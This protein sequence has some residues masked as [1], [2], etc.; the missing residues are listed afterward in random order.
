MKKQHQFS[1][2]RLRGTIF[3]LSLICVTMCS[4][5]FYY[6]SRQILLRRTCL[7]DVTNLHQ[8]QTMA[9]H[10][11]S[12]V[13]NISYQVYNDPSVAYLLYGED[14]E[15]AKVTTAMAQLQNYRNA[16]P[17]VDSIYIYNGNWDSVSVSSSRFGTFDAPIN[18]KGAFFDRQIGD[19][20]QNKVDFTSKG[21]PFPRIVPYK[22]EELLYYTYLT[23]DTF[24]NAPMKSAVFVNF[25]GAWMDSV[26]ASD[27]KTDSNTLILDKDGL[28]ISGNSPWPFFTDLASQHFY[29][30]MQQESEEGYI[31]SRINEEKYLV[32]FY[33]PESESWQYIRL[34]PYKLVI[35][36]I[37]HSF[38][39]MFLLTLLLILLGSLLSYLFSR[40]LSAPIL[41]MQEDMRQMEQENRQTRQASKQ[42]K[43]QN[44][45]YGYALLPSLTTDGTLSALNPDSE[46]DMVYLL[47]LIR[48]RNYRSLY[49][50]HDT[51][52]RNLLR[53]A[54]LNVASE[55]CSQEFHTESVDMGGANHLAVILSASQKKWEL[56]TSDMLLSM[57]DKV[58]RS[59]R[60]ALELEINC[61]ISEPFYDL[62]DTPAAYKQNKEAFYYCLFY[63]EK[64]AI[65]VQMIRDNGRRHYNYPQAQEDRMVEA[66]MNSNQ[67]KAFEI[68][69]EI[70][71]ST[72]D[73]S[74]SAIVLAVSHLSL[75]ISNVIDEIQKN[76]FIEFP[77]NI[78]ARCPSINAPYEAESIEE[79]EKSFQVLIR[80]IITALNDKRSSRS[81][82][83]LQKITDLIQAQYKDPNCCLE[84]I[85]GE[86]GL[87]AAYVGKLYK[88]YTLKS[89]P[90]Q[91]SE[92]RMTEARRLLRECRKMTVAEIAQ[93]TGFSSNSY[94]SKAFR[95][96][97][98]M[99][100]NEYRT[101]NN[102]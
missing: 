89:I 6:A 74:F 101:L 13:G 77:E 44:F 93:A 79:I 7:L 98:G 46:E 41:T 84:S 54:V 24:T 76:R 38:Q 63:P 10:M 34:T 14:F 50:Q 56:T 59:V 97:N 92:L 87:S 86:V 28:V 90:E 39:V 58:S 35:G 40:R 12:I 100:P 71:Y 99:T 29:Q 91:I 27:S 36:E 65:Q 52:G 102:L 37:N 18:G 23:G 68:L 15:P 85:A 70:L 53:Y 31:L 78:L 20:L 73:Y 47:V 8:V 69:K 33:K 9:A 55:I 81:T 25:S 43:L 32:S 11:K 80:Y 22:N 45:L 62:Q 88:R 72:R 19:L 95:K 16:N 66:M 26:I 48:I 67:E 51:N 1:F 17:Y 64:S 83:L 75:T 3:T 60:Q 61:V 4:V 5:L 21:Q 30:Q 49:Q 2:I 57:L 82:D 94:F 96:E 42:H